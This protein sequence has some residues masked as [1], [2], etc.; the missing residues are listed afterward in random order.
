MVNFLHDFVGLDLSTADSILEEVDIKSG[1]PLEFHKKDISVLQ[2]KKRKAWEKV[3]LARCNFNI[4]PNL[5]P[6]AGIMFHSIWQKTRDG[7]TLV[8]IK[9]D[10]NMIPFFASNLAKLIEKTLGGFLCQGDFAICT[11]PKRRHKTRNFATLVTLSIA[12]IIGLTFYDD[13]AIA[14]NKQRINAK[15]EINNLPKEQNIIVVDDFCTTGSTFK[16]MYD[17]LIKHNKNTAFFA[18][19]NNKL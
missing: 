9:A 16:S 3:E 19:I 4:Y 6:R 2:D 14:K 1:K 12:D 10:D 11:T 15:F 17:V 7:R 8:D 18:G 13:V 5:T